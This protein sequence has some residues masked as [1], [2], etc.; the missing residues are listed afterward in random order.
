MW[1]APPMTS[2]TPNPLFSFLYA[3]SQTPAPESVWDHSHVNY[4]FSCEIMF[5][6][7]IFYTCSQLGTN[8]LTQLALF[9]QNCYYLL[10][11][12]YL[13]LVATLLLKLNIFLL[14]ILYLLFRNHMDSGYLSCI[15]PVASASVSLGSIER[16]NSQNLNMSLAPYSL[17]YKSLDWKR[18]NS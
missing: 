9:A 18:C 5:A 7:L 17:I 11:L 13:L 4:L 14:I 8:I 16:S 6:A 1:L 15:N 10:L 2:W 3:V 12:H